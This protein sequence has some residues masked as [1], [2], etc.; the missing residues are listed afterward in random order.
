MKLLHTGD[1]HLG[2]VLKGVTRL[3]EQRSICAEIVSIARH[4][5]VDVVLVA[6]DVFDTAV[7]APDAQELAWSTLLALRGTGAEVVVIAGNHDSPEAFDAVRPVFAAAGV[8]IAGRLR[9]PDDAGSVAVT[10]ATG[11]RARVAMIPFVSQRRI[12]RAAD[13][14]ELD[15]AARQGR[16]AQQL[17]RFVSR[18]AETFRPDEVNVVLMHGTVTGA[19]FG[20]GE[21]EAQSVFDY[22]LPA[23]AFP[24]TASYVAL[25]HL[26]RAQQVAAPCPAWYA[27]APLAVDFGEDDHAPSVNLVEVDPG[28]PA[29]VRVRSLASARR[30]RSISGTLAELALLAPDVDG[31]LVRVLVR[32]PPRVGLADEVRA[33]VAGA[34]EVRVESVG[35]AAAPRTERLSRGSSPSELFDAYLGSQGLVDARIR[36]LFTTLADQVLSSDAAADAESA[37]A[38]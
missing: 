23:S 7:P 12:V 20:G 16:Y 5:A 4:E 2:K 35:G 26:H 31:A 8:T 30:L 11:Q 33:I 38:R 25:G 15:E 19:R 14:F 36:A 24:T 10:T 6:G 27:G 32:E 22:H 21:R 37:G 1:W 28:L 18:F 9:S 29:R 17:M 34:I 3:D 13:V